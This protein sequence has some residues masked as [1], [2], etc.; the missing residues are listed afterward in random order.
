MNVITYPCPE[1]NDDFGDICWYNTLQ[2][3]LLLIWINFYTSMDK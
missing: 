2:G 1:L 3:S